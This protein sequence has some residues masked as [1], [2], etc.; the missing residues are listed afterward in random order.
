MNVPGQCAVAP[1]S[2]RGFV[3]AISTEGQ[4]VRVAPC[5]REVVPRSLGVEFGRAPIK[6]GELS[7][8]GLRRPSLIAA[9][10]D[11]VVR[12]DLLTS[13][14]DELY[15]VS[16]GREICADLSCWAAGI[17]VTTETV[18]V[19]TRHG[20]E[21]AVVCWRNA[22]GATPPVSLGALE[23]CAGPFRVGRH[24]GAYTAD[25]VFVIVDGIA[26]AVPLPSG[27][28]AV[29]TIEPGGTL[30]TP[31]G[32][33][34]YVALGDR[35][36]IPAR[37][38]GAPTLL[39]ITQGN[40]VRIVEVPDVTPCVYVGT[41]HGMVLA[42]DGKLTL[43][44]DEGTKV[45]EEPK[46]LGRRCALINDVLAA[47]FVKYPNTGEVLRVYVG[48]QQSDCSIEHIDDFVHA[49]GFHD[50]GPALALAYLDH[51]QRTRIASFPWVP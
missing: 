14:V 11:R 32:N 50:V 48:Q 35:A 22:P 18:A 36:Y 8:N 3:F 47:G 51:D 20:G 44:S 30:Q 4:A 45:R 49:I 2:Y 7:I 27:T 42:A 43:F 46:L 24:L 13:E 10:A 31:A 5:S 38:N 29:D 39:E 21:F 15:A 28:V 9:S 17:D 26:V 6:L 37:R 16:D 1:V 33:L 19:L 23:R 41:E 12:L 34:P 25:R 40:P